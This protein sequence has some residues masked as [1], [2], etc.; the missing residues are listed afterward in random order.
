M[1]IPRPTWSVDI[2]LDGGSP[3][4]ASFTHDV[5]NN[6][7]IAHIGV[8]PKPE[9]CRHSFVVAVDWTTKK[10]LRQTRFNN[11]RS[12]KLSVFHDPYHNNRTLLCFVD[13]N[14]PTDEN[15]RIID[16]LTGHT[17]IKFFP[18]AHE[19]FPIEIS[20]IRANTGKLISTVASASTSSVF[21]GVGLLPRLPKAFAVFQVNTI[22]YLRCFNFLTGYIYWEALVADL[23]YFN[24]EPNEAIRSL[25]C[26]PSEVLILVEFGTDVNLSLI[27]T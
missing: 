15:L 9:D 18:E 7:I 8:M 5:R 22:C 12:P 26:T 6:L 16:P 19:P 13:G 21:D 14:F 27:C 23:A 10:I 20:L 3:A 11:R 1:T 17:L 24:I 4:Y 2:D 25:A